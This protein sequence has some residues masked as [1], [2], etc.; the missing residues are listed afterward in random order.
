MAVHEFLAEVAG[1]GEAGEVDF[2][3]MFERLVGVAV[4]RAVGILRVDRAAAKFLS[5]LIEEVEM[6]EEEGLQFFPGGLVSGETI[7][8]FEDAAADHEA[9]D[10]WI[11]LR[12]LFYGG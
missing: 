4:L 10:A 12:E 2:D 9:V 6:V 8:V 7:G 3:E 11:F 5:A 1:A